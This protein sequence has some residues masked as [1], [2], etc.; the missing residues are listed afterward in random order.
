MKKLNISIIKAKK[1]NDI[2][3]MISSERL[4]LG[5]SPTLISEKIKARLKA[6]NV[7]TAIIIINVS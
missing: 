5:A 1:P 7:K 6:M 4:R 3:N 2:V